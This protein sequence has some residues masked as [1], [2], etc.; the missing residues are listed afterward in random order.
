VGEERGERAA[1]DMG[2]GEG[3]INL[4]GDANRAAAAAAR[5]WEGERV[6]ASRPFVDDV[7]KPVMRTLSDCWAC[8]QRLLSEREAKGRVRYAPVRGDWQQEP[9][10]GPA[11]MMRPP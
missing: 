10:A 2:R 1:D 5:T 9:R 3:T 6:C 7:T 8:K 11:G 4:A